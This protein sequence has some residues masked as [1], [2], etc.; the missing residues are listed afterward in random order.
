MAAKEGRNLWKEISEGIWDVIGMGPEMLQSAPVARLFRNKHFVQKLGFV[1]IDEVHLVL[2]WGLSFRKDYLK[3]C[4]LH[5]CLLTQVT[6]LAMSAS[7][8]DDSHIKVQGMLGFKTNQ[9]HDIKLP[10]DHPDLKYC[11]Q[12]LLNSTQGTMFP[13]LAWVIPPFINSPLDLTLTLFACHTIDKVM[14]LCQWLM[15]ELA[16]AYL[17]QT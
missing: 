4:E 1:F 8:H 16:K 2:Q 13:D 10:I 11:P 3:L 5:A 6:F 7:L 12:F 17:G 15:V 14:M 9:F